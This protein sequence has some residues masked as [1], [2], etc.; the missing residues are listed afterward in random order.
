[1]EQIGYALVSEQNE[2]V[3]T[4]GNALG[5]LEG[6]PD[7]IVLANGDRVHGAKAGDTFGGCRLLPRFGELGST[8]ATSVQSDKV[9]TTFVVMPEAV[10]T[11]R[12]RRLSLGFQYDFGDARGVHRIGTSTQDM[13]GW[14][15]V[16]MASQV[17]IALSQPS[18]TMAIVTDTG[19]VSVTAMEWQ[20]ILLAATQ[21]R[22]PIWAASFALQAM[23][24]IPADYASDGY[25]A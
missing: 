1:M 8:N 20:Q 16:T 9:V 3:Q 18:A 23:S 4:W 13:K 17:A 22:Q 19:P 5:Q 7:V 11:E 15:E 2:V 6:L 14:S 21:F 10:I 24:P 25:W 12:E